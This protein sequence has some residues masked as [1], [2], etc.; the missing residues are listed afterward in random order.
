MGGVRELRALLAMAARLVVAL[1]AWDHWLYASTVAPI[2]RGAALLVHLGLESLALLPVVACALGASVAWAGP[3]RP[4]WTARL[5]TA[6]A[7]SLACVLL[8]APAVG[9][10]DLVHERVSVGWP[11]VHAPEVGGTP[12]ALPALCSTTAPP[13][14]EMAPALPAGIAGRIVSAVSYAFRHA[15]ADQLVVVPFVVLGIVFPWRR[16]RARRG[17]AAPGG[18]RIV[19]TPGR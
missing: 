9:L 7:V 14:A 19:I 11:L 4:A 17:A 12:L 5:E 6:G 15:L 3:P 2:D 1:V 13:G 16:P 18:W 8:L 10:R